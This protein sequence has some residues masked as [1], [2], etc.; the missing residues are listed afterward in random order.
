MHGHLLNH[1]SQ[2][3]S[4]HAVTPLRSKRFGEKAGREKWEYPFLKQYC[5]KGVGGTASSAVHHCPFYD[6]A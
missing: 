6:G 3:N 4:T 5:F 1:E 2:R